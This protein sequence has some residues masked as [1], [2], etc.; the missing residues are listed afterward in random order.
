VLLIVRGH[1]TYITDDGSVASHEVIMSVLLTAGKKASLSKA[2]KEQKKKK[3]AAVAAR[4]S[5]TANRF[6]HIKA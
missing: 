5:V 6:D 3:T 4:K 1:Y 2:A